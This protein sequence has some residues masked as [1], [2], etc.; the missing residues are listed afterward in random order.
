MSSGIAA[1]LQTGVTLASTAGSTST[2][3]QKNDPTRVK[4]AAQQFEALMISEMMKSIRES[5]ENGPMAEEKDQAGS[6]AMQLAE[7]Q[8]AQ[9][10]A[11]RGGLG[12]ASMLTKAF[13]TTD[14]SSDP[15]SAAQ[16]LPTSR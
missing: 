2:A 13:P 16:S 6:S 7:E 10:L 5:E 15:P 4:H 9:A 11:S 8:F 14:S 1:P 12:L 3:G